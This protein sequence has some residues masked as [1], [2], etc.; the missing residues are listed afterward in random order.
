MTRQQ[1]QERNWKIARL[2]CILPS[3]TRLL[4][5]DI[6]GDDTAKVEE[7]QALSTY[8]WNKIK[9]TKAKHFT[10][11]TCNPIHGK[12]TKNRKAFTCDFC[13]SWHETLYTVKGTQ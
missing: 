7:F 6:I 4:P 2:S 5:T 1:A 11:D 10:C 13:D 3:I 8:F 9:A 12:I